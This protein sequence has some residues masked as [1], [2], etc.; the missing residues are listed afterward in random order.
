M[1]KF[2]TLGAYILLHFSTGLFAQYTVNTTL[3]DINTYPG[4]EPKGMSKFGNEIIM[5]LKSPETGVEP[6][7]Y[8]TTDRSF[9]LVK[10]LDNNFWDSLERHD[11]YLIGSKFYYFATAG[12]NIQLWVTDMETKVTTKV[13]EFNEYFSS[14]D[15]LTAKVVNNKLFFNFKNKLYSTDGTS[16]G[17]ILLTTMNNT[18]TRLADL[19][20]EVYFLKNTPETGTEL[21]KSNGTITGTKIVKDLNPGYSSSGYIYEEKIYTVNNKIL[22]YANGFGSNNGIYVTDGT[23]EGTTLLNKTFALFSKNLSSDHTGKIIFTIGDDLWISDA[24][25]A[26]SLNYSLPG[27][28]GFMQFQN[29]IILNANSG[30]YVVDENEIISKLTDSENVTLQAAA[31]SSAGNYLILTERGNTDSE[32]YI[33]DNSELKKTNI[34]YGGDK[35]FV[36]TDDRLIFNGYTES[37]VDG[38][39]IQKNTELFYYNYDGTTG[40]EKEFF[41]HSSSYPRFFTAHQNKVFFI[42]TV[43]YFDQLFMVDETNKVEQVGILSKVQ[44]PNNWSGYNPAVTSGN[45]IYYKGA[46]VIRSNGT[47]QGTQQISLP[48]NESLL[49]IYPLSDTAVLLKSYNNQHGFMRLWKLN[50]NSTNPELLVEMPS[51]FNDSN[52]YEYKKVGNFI[53]FKMQNIDKTELWKSDGSIANTI[54]LRDL[55]S[56]YFMKVLMQPLGQK[57]FFVETS[58]NY[59]ENDKL[60][61]LDINTDE[62]HFVK[63]ELSYFTEGS[64]VLNEELYFTS[65]SLDPYVS[66]RLNKTNGLATGTFGISPLPYNP[67]KV[68]KCGNRVFMDSDDNDASQTLYSTDGTTAG[69]YHTTPGLNYSKMLGCIKNELYFKNWN[70]IYITNG[71]QGNRNQ[72]NIVGEGETLNVSSIYD[73]AALQDRILISYQYANKGYELMVSD[74]F[75]SPLATQNIRTKLGDHSIVVYPN[76]AT[77]EIT[78]KIPSGEKVLRVE[79]L[80]VA[81]RTVANSIEEKINIEKLPAGVYFIK[82]HTKEK[83]YSGKVIKK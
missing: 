32:T 68:L 10:N 30:T 5:S 15:F 74:I 71:E 59:S 44:S 60:Y 20:G 48:I 39:N 81:G 50:T 25:T 82:V 35:N 36:E 77:S 34:K 28:T 83:M 33:F 67:T 78:I 65:G 9:Q 51:T 6:F 64:F 49:E 16:E 70:S 72:V 53:Y 47:S 1:K 80:D 54:K 18:E 29:K 11:F 75:T 63:E 56:M 45:Y 79:F 26:H 12:S 4:S 21:W 43:G 52:W 3:K 23:S 58:N 27:I 62:S 31:K 13:K 41:T 55:P 42:A 22:Y 76:P 38:Y 46:T 8:N 37:D 40:L 19:N 61:Y 17:T 7:K 57:L 24:V 2:Y 73:F 66:Y 14:S 69:T